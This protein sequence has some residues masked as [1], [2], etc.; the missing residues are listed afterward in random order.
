MGRRAGFDKGDDD[1]A[2]EHAQVLHWH[3]RQVPHQRGLPGRQQRSHLVEAG[4]LRRY[5]AQRLIQ[6][7]PHL[8][9]PADTINSY[10][11]DSQSVCNHH[12]LNR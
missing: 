12:I 7:L 2:D 1:V 5:R 11:L 4:Y 10:L 9:P 3:D 6:L 8:H